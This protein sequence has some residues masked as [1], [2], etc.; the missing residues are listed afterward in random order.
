MV[1][2]W[3]GCGHSETDGVRV[4][5]EVKIMKAEEH[6]VGVSIRDWQ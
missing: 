3:G 6:I 5:E 4:W 2:A 1:G